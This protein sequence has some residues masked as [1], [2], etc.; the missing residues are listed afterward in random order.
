MNA[1]HLCLSC[2]DCKS[3]KDPGGVRFPALEAARHVDTS[4]GRYLGTRGGTLSTLSD[5][6]SP[7]L[8]K[9]QSQKRLG[10]PET[11]FRSLF[12]LPG[13]AHTKRHGN[14]GQSSK[15]GSEE[16]EDTESHGSNVC[17]CSEPVLAEDQPKVQPATC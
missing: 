13:H 9:P 5:P 11:R 10:Q 8:L 15:Q 1:S 2:R 17:Q 14:L 7:R 3:A 16:A 12:R 4:T 6:S